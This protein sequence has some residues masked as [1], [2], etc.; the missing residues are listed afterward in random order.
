MGVNHIV[1]LDFIWRKI[2]NIWAGGVSSEQAAGGGEWEL[3]SMSAING[4]IYLTVTD[5]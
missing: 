4:S 1:V 2:W 5:F 3:Q